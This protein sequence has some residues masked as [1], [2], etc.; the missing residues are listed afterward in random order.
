MADEHTTTTS[1]IKFESD[2]LRLSETFKTYRINIPISE[3]ST[4]KDAI[5]A[6]LKKCGVTPKIITYNS[7]GLGLVAIAGLDKFTYIG[8]TENAIGT[9]YAYSVEKC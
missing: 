6:H 1:T 9:H 8:I 5:F 7:G 3:G 4:P 2:V